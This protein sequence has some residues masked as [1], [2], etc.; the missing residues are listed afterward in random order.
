MGYWQEGEKERNHWE[1]LN[2]GRKII[3]KCILKK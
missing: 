3:L 2:V 1:N